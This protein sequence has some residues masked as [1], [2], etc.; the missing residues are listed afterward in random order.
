M[1]HAAKS[2]LVAASIACVCLMSPRYVEAR[3][4][5]GGGGRGGGF[6]GGFKGGGFGGFKGGGFGGGFKGEEF[7]GGC[8]GEEFGGGFKGERFGGF[9]AGGTGSGFRGSSRG[10]FRGYGGM[11]YSGGK[12]WAR[13]GGTV[14]SFRSGPLKSFDGAGAFNHVPAAP[15]SVRRN[16]GLW[17][18]HNRDR[19]RDRFRNRELVDGDG[20]FGFWGG[21]YWGFDYPWWNDNGTAFWYSPTSEETYRNPFY[22]SDY[23]YGGYDYGAPITQAEQSP[24]D[25]SSFTAAR[26]EFYA[27]NYKLAL[28]SIDHAILGLPDN[29]DVHQFHS[30]IYFTLGDYHRAATVAHTVLDAGPGWDW[31]V[32]QSFYPSPDIYTQQLR[33]LERY[34]REHPD[35][36]APRFLL[37]YHYLMLG[38]MTAARNQLARVVTLEPRDKLS[39]NVLAGLSRTLNVNP[40]NPVSGGAA[41]DALTASQAPGG[42]STIQLTS[43]LS[44]TGM[45]TALGTT[46]NVAPGPIGLQ[47]ASPETAAMQLVGTW[48]ATPTPGITI[49]TTLQP[50]G[51][52]VWKVAQGTHTESFSGA[53]VRRGDSLVLTRTDGKKMDG[54]LTMKG[55]TGFRFRLKNT[56]PND[57]GLEFSK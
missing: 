42:P 20:D 55:N 32:L 33:A 16:N 57:P 2:F 10:G 9:K 5:T 48:N 40:R 52:F 7:G 23:I 51:Q 8:K 14:S 35:E 44:Q 41:A 19:D 28:L 36:P 18:N 43:G 1:L 12:S 50:D 31:S 34:I 15:M 39:A 25:D 26:D 21:P 46:K 27:G 37:G 6:G 56:I 47:P 24:Q 17:G 22:T 29:P 3:G 49:E 4:G 11:R 38:H 30:L 45:P 53:Y 54:V 13:L